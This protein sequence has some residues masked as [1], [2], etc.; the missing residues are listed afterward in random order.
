MQGAIAKRAE[1][2]YQQLSPE[3]QE[4]ACWALL[5]LTQP[6]DGTEDTLLAG[7]AGRADHPACEGEAVEAVVRRLADARLLTTS[8]DEQSGERAVDLAHEALIRNWP[9]LRGWLD[10]DRAGLRDPPATVRSCP[11]VA[12]SGVEPGLLYRGARSPKPVSGASNMPTCL[13]PSNAP[14]S[15]RAWRCKTPSDGRSSGG[16]GSP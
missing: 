10:A 5:R 2:T 14:S 8:Q 4:A 16:L 6:V 1:T 7:D 9:Q 3:Q 11:G 15:M 12:A 13:T